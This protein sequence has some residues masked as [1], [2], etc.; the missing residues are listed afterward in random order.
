MGKRRPFGEIG[1]VHAQDDRTLHFY[2][3]HAPTYVASGAAGASRHLPSFLELLPPRSKIL[4]LGCGGGRDAQAMMAAGHL[5]DPTDGTAEIAHKAEQ[6]LQVP[7]RVMRF[8]QL[9][10]FEVYDAVWAN[11]SLLHVPRPALPSILEKIRNALK[12]GGLHHATYK[13]GGK[14]GRDRNGRYFN[15]LSPDEVIRMYETSGTWEFLSVSDYLGGGYDTTV[16][17]PWVA[18]LVKKPTSPRNQTASAMS[19]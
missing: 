7:V 12:P 4:E 8:D 3:D 13:A 14:E 10:V 6:L 9:N 1:L 2:A 16:R 5:V 15:Y 11:A 19:A 17:G 18:A